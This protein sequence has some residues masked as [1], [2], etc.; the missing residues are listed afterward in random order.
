MDFSKVNIQKI[1]KSAMNNRFSDFSPQDFEDFIAYLFKTNGYEVVQTK[2]SGDY[3]VDLIITKGAENISVQVKRYSKSVKVGVKD[4]NQVL[5]GRDYYK[6]K[7][8]KVVTT[9]SFTKPAINLA[10][11]TGADLWDWDTLRKHICDTYLNGMNHFE[12]FKDKQKANKRNGNLSFKFSKVQYNISMKGGG[13]GTLIYIKVINNSDKNFNVFLGLPT[14]ISQTNN[15]FEATAYFSGYFSSGTIYSGCTIEACFV[16][17]Y[18]QLSRVKN[19][20]K[21]VITNKRGEKSYQNFI[22]IEHLNESSTENKGCCIATT[23]YGSSCNPAI[24]LLSAWKDVI[25][26]NSR[27]GRLFVRNY[28]HI[29]PFL[30]HYFR[31]RPMLVWITRRVLDTF[32]FYLKTRYR[33]N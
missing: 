17:D 27:I 9:S 15:Q 13:L 23:V 30:T 6:C 31:T 16:F 4:I 12:Y 25:L 26:A 14:Y 32:A 21:L 11:N 18:E 5:G 20:D 19:G 2:Y 33:L 29:S 22:K 10:K 8:V 28:Y 7:S 3:G 24:N 1:L